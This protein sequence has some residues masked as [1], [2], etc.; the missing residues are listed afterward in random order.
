MPLT[1]PVRETDAA[2]SPV[3]ERL[4]ADALDCLQANLAVLAD[5]QQAGAHLALGARLRF[6]P[7]VPAVGWPSMSAKLD[8]RLAE[9]GFLG[10]RAT[11][12][13]DGVDGPA[14]RTLAGSAA[15]SPLYVVGDAYSM[16]WLPYAGHRH[17]EHS[18]LLM[19]ADPDA[20]IVDAYHND[21]E[22]GEA[23]PGVWRLPATALDQ[24]AECGLTVITLAVGPPPQPD[25]ATVLAG[26][27][28]AADAAAP[29]LWRYAAA[30]RAA[31]GVGA[32]D[33][34]AIAAAALDQFILDV[35]LLGRAW[36]LHALWLA[37]LGAASATPADEHAQAWLRF[38]VQAFVAGRRAQRGQA[39]S[40]ALVD[41]LDGLLEKTVALTRALTADPI[42]RTAS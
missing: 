37:S 19:T 5:R 41:Q 25:A 3:L 29:E 13:R 18:F 16:P 2:W 38:S 26:N 4:R 27:A 31:L 28:T 7:S 10:I 21:T 35:W 17:L 33:P 36:R 24:A 14:L 9:A 23:R 42:A 12:R 34:T 8:A 30:V 11:G 6:A 40:A 15:G 22:W 39:P 1:A 20:V 32:T